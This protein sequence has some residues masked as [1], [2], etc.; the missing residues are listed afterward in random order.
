MRGEMV[1]KL[2]LTCCFERSFSAVWS[3]CRLNIEVAVKYTHPSK[4]YMSVLIELTPL[5]LSSPMLM[6]ISRPKSYRLVVFA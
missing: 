1:R 4:K 2:N 3:K 5:N 6:Y